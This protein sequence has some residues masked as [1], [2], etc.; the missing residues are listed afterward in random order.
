MYTDDLEIVT[1]IIHAIKQS[2]QG[3]GQCNLVESYSN[4][5]GKGVWRVILQWKQASG[6]WRRPH[7]TNDD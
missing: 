2:K 4:V 3:V 7:Y 1:F 6:V 5:N